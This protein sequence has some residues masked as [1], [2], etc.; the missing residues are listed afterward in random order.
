ML[1]FDGLAGCSRTVTLRGR[2]VNCSV[3]GECPSLTELI[4]Y[5]TFCGSCATDKVQELSLLAHEE[6]ITCQDY[7]S[8]LLSGKEH[9]L[10]DVRPE[11]EFE[12]CH[13]DH[14]ISILL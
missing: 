13:L 2:Q 11:T 12:I 3:C 5:Q 9:Y 6:R 8:V 10:I 14:A 4:D 1:V 7:Q